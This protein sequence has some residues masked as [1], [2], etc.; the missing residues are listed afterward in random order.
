MRFLS[1]FIILFWMTLCA[2]LFSIQVFQGKTYQKTLIAQSQRKEKIP[3]E[4]GNIFD[5]NGNAL[6]RNIAHYTIS[7]NPQIISNK[8]ALASFISNLTKKSKQF[9]LKKL[10]SNKKFEFLER[11]ILLSQAQVE[12]V[13]KFESLNI[14]KSYRRSYPHGPIVSQIIGYN[15][16]DGRGISGL[17]KDYD[18]EL[19][20]R[21]GIAIKSKGWKGKF[22]SRSGLPFTAPIDGS[23]ITLTIDIDYQSILQEELIKRKKETEAKSAMG[24]IMNPQS[25]EI[26][27]MSSVPSFDNNSFSQYP[28]S[29]H[30]SKVLTDQ[31][32]P[33]STFKIVAATASLAENKVTL[34]QEFSCENGKFDY[35]GS[36][37]KDHDPYEQLTIS[38]IIKH[39]SNIGIIKI[40]EKVGSSS[41]YKYAKLFG[42]GTPTNFDMAGETAGKIKPEKEWSRISIGQISMGHEVAVNT[43]QLAVAFSAIANNGFLIKPFIINKIYNRNENSEQKTLSSVKRQISSEDKI[44]KIKDMLRQVVLDGTG[45]EADIKGWEVAG[46]T[47]TAQKYIDGKYSNDHFI[48]N[49]VGFFPASKPEILSVI[50]L[51]EPKSPLHWGGTGAAVAFNRV[52]KRIINM[53]DSISPPMKQGKENA[54]DLLTFSKKKKKLIDKQIPFALSTKN[55]QEQIKVPNVIGKSLKTAIRILSNAGLKVKVNGSGKVIDQFPKPGKSNNN[56]K[57]CILTLE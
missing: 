14:K 32:E 21:S 11:N 31:F 22:Q 8:N 16:T 28:I 33:G 1:S 36:V 52:M 49:F 54:G 9:Y 4:R 40:A 44:I 37:I 45:T 24:I 18:T 2:K 23:D 29:Q 15:D 35:F 34:E 42:F 13:H 5:R 27:A 39:S 53:D 7:V 55:I 38:Q 47:G 43:L 10:N 51:D 57:L 56:S 17:E 41:I 19:L 25:G 12:L 6:T 50:V 3:A 30:H 20:G 48:S 46:K 26:L